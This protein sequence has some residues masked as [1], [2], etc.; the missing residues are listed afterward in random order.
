MISYRWSG[1]ITSATPT[2][3]AGD[4]ALRDTS[5]SRTAPNI[6]TTTR[7]LLIAAGTDWAYY[8][9]HTAATNWTKILDS[10]TKGTDSTTMYL[11]A[12]IANA[13]TYPNGNFATSSATDQ[14]FGSIVAYEVTESA[15]SLPPHITNSARAFAHLLPR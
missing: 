3:S 14:Y 11:H 7:A 10:Q 5:T 4:T 2:H 15:A 1:G 13:G 9:T 6:T 12:R 8:N